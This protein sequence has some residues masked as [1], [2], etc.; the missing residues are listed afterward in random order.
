MQILAREMGG[1]RRSAGSHF[2]FGDR[3]RG[4]VL[5]EALHENV[6]HGRDVEREDLGDTQSTDD[7]ETKG[8]AGVGAGAGMSEASSR[9]SACAV[10]GADFILEVKYIK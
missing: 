5:G 8:A 2:N 10:S 3:L 4:E 6:E 1:R 7:G 9:R